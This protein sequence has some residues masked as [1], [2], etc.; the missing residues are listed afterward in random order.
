MANSET[1]LKKQEIK[2]LVQKEMPFW[3]ETMES[4][5]LKSYIN[6]IVTHGHTPL[7]DI[8]ESVR[9]KNMGDYVPEAMRKRNDFLLSTEM[10]EACDKVGAHYGFELDQF[11]LYFNTRIFQRKEVLNNITLF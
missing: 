7:V 11:H 3:Q 9:R 8:V 1:V 5:P 10:A 2:D 4:V 6:L